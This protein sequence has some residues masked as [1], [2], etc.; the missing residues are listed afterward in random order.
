M[1]AIY[2]NRVIFHLPDQPGGLPGCTDPDRH[3]HSAEADGYHH[4]WTH[5]RMI[6]VLLVPMAIMPLQRWALFRILSRQDHLLQKPFEFILDDR[7]GP[8]N[9]SGLTLDIEVP[10][11]AQEHGTMVFPEIVESFVVVE[12]S[13]QSKTFDRGGEK[14][15]T[16]CGSH[17]EIGKKA[18]L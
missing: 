10:S 1:G 11:T 5:A 2:P 13:I 3:T 4:P 18:P 16:S 17:I 15:L 7:R 6:G 14:H 9:G 8:I 12:G